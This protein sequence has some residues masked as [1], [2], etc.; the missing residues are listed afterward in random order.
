MRKHAYVLRI[1]EKKGCLIED[2]IRDYAEQ[3]Y[4]RTVMSEIMGLSKTAIRR[5]ADAYNIT[6][7]M[8]TKKE[9]R[10]NGGRPLQVAMDAGA[11]SSAKFVTHNGETLCIAE[12]AERQGLSRN[13]VYSRI[14]RGASVKDALGLN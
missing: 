6:L 7:P 14:H 3:G 13:T 11:M 9:L 2:I 12:W 10:A 1:E 8:R 4:G 5:Y